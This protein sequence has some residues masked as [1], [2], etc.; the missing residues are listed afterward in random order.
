MDIKKE[1]TFLPEGKRQQIFEAR[2]LILEKVPEVEKIFLFGSYAKGKWVEDR[3]FENGILY[4]YLSDYDFLVVTSGPLGLVNEYLCQDKIVNN[5]KHKIPINPHVQDFSG[6]NDGL[7]LGQY[8]FVEIL[9]E[10]ILLFDSNLHQFSKPKMLTEEQIRNLALEKYNKWYKGGLRILKYA[11][12]SL[13]VSIS[14]NEELKDIAFLLHQAAERFYTC[15][16]LV[17]GNYKPK[18]HNL[19]KLR[20]YVK[21]YSKELYLLFSPLPENPREY[22]LF[23]LLKSSYIDA[24]Y[25]EEFEI[26]ETELNFLIEKIDRMGKIV[27]EVCKPKIS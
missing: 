25:K 27:K 7:E 13:E 16:L 5:W 14:E 1:I 9:N 4:E 26:S 6:V 17:F 8:F 18:T 20:E 22:Y 21:V 19:S 11:K 3:Y 15:V 10:G 24:R 23:N 2:D 12:V